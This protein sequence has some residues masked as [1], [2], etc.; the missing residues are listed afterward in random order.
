MGV[1]Q[2]ELLYRELLFSANYSVRH[3]DGEAFAIMHTTFV[4]YPR[5]V[6]IC[7]NAHYIC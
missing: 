3:S 6:P 4:K 1:L 5:V 2:C 7:H